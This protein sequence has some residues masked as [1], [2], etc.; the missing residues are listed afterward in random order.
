MRM[1][2]QMYSFGDEHRVEPHDEDEQTLKKKNRIKIVMYLFTV[3]LGIMT[4]FSVL[5]FSIEFLFNIVS[6]VSV[7]VIS[8]L[9]PFMLYRKLV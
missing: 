4:A 8:F 7:P 5:Q 3:I 9:F 1:L 2:I 6:T